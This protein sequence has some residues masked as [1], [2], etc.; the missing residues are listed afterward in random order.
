MNK[1][2]LSSRLLLSMKLKA[3]YYSSPGDVGLFL[4]DI[5]SLYELIRLSLDE[6]YKDFAFSRFAL[7]RG[8]RKLTEI[9]KLQIQNL[10]MQSP[11]EVATSVTVYAGM[12]ASI[13]GTFWILIQILEKIYNLKLDHEKLRL[14][15]AKLQK[16]LT[17]DILEE[18]AF[19]DK[20]ALVERKSI[21]Y[22]EIIERRLSRAELEVVELQV[23]ADVPGEE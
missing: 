7:Y 12:V 22:I 1:G 10:S 14:E 13:L 15:V 9:D 21:E 17:D 11:I 3:P 4:Y 20:T 19:P 2:T 16:A 5:D 6:S 23:I 8:H 18:Q